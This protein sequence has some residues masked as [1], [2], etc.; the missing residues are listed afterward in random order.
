MLIWLVLYTF[1]LSLQ[2]SVVQGISIN[3]KPM[4]FNYLQIVKVSIQLTQLNEDVAELIYF[5][6]VFICSDKDKRRVSLKR[7]SP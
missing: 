2:Q 5:M 4:Y 3:I 7:P 1:P 6:V